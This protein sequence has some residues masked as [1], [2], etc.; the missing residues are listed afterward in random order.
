KPF[1]GIAMTNLTRL[2]FPKMYGSL[3]LERLIMNPGGMF[4][5]T[6]VS[7]VVGA[8][9]CAGKLSLLLEYVEETV[10]TKTM[11]KIKTKAMDFLLNS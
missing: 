11:E 4:P 10:N 8:V 2:D 7:L 5:L 6:I 1:L 3:E 9:T